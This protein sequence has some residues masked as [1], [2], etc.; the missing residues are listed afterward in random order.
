M[1]KI[2]IQMHCWKIVEDFKNINEKIME[3]TEVIIQM[4]WSY[5]RIFLTWKYLKSKAPV[6]QPAEIKTNK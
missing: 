5:G 1:D 3:P 2:P 4:V 6:M